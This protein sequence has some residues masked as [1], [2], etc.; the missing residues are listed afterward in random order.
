MQGFN[1]QLTK[2]AGWW[3]TLKSGVQTFTKAPGTYMKEQV[4]HKPTRAAISGAALGAGAGGAVGA[5]TADEGDRGRGA[6][7]GA[8]RGAMIGAP[9]GLGASALTAGGRQAFREGGKRFWERQKYT[10]TGKGINEATPE[11]LAKARELKIMPEEI[12]QEHFMKDGVLNQKKWD[13]ALAKQEEQ[14]KAFEAG[15][16]S[17]PG[18]LHGMMTHPIDTLR[19][20]WRRSDMMMKGFTGL[21]AYQAGRGFIDKPEEGGPGRLQKGMEGLGQTVGWLA[22]PP[23]MIAGSL[24]GMG[25]GKLTGAVGKLGDIGVDA[26]RRKKLQAHLAQ[27]VENPSALTPVNTVGAIR[28]M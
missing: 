23:T 6:L 11:G 10:L 21:G 22:A 4:L 15:H 8:V 3:D 25:A 28:G 14:R 20:G 17:A 1:T 13:K 27:G 12:K 19:S 24:V 9:I 7:R 2:E 5:A 26:R 16:Y 18:V